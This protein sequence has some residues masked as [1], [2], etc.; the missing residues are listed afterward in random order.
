MYIRGTGNLMKLFSSAA[1]GRT[2][3]EILPYGI[4]IND[5][6]TENA[7][8]RQGGFAYADQTRSSAG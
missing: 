6:T 8:L 5:D 1:A 2:F 3:Q 4:T 7:S